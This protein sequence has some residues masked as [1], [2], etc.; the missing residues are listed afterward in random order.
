MVC[1]IWSWRIHDLK[2]TPKIIPFL[3]FIL[4]NSK[5]FAAP[6]FRATGIENDRLPHYSSQAQRRAREVAQYLHSVEIRASTV[7][8]HLRH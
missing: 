7:H 1:H 3:F 2:Q 4:K 5:L 6:L 8:I